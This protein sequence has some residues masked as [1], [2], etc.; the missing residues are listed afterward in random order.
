MNSLASYTLRSPILVIFIDVFL[1]DVLHGTLYF[2]VVTY[3]VA[4]FPDR[5][6]FGSAWTFG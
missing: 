3:P 1:K 4:G 2:V 6:L 5:Q